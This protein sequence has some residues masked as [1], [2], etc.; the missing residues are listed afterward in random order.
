MKNFKYILFVYLFQNILINWES[1][2]HQLH[3]QMSFLIDL[4]NEALDS[5]VDDQQ[6][7]GEHQA[8]ASVLY[9]NLFNLFR[10]QAK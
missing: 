2:H 5:C 6:M 1:D 4:F 10:S 9:C 3:C 8:I 7:N